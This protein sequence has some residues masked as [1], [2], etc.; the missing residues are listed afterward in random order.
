MLVYFERLAGEEGGVGVRDAEAGEGAR[1]LPRPL[2][3][4]PPPA[5]APLRPLAAAQEGNLVT[6]QLGLRLQQL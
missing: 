4:E 5:A 1:R 3:R 6:R 2:P